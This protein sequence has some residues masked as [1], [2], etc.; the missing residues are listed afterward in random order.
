MKELLK[1]SLNEDNDVQTDIRIRNREEYDIISGAFL[2]MLEDFTKEYKGDLRKE[3]IEI[4]PALT[5]IGAV[6]TVLA[7]NKELRNDFNALIDYFIE[8]N[9]ID[10]PADA[11]PKPEAPS[12]TDPLVIA[13]SIKSSGPKS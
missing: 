8:Q 6:G 10:S 3:P 12:D 1:I 4:H 9:G 11:K 2:D 13:L 5:I 7:Q